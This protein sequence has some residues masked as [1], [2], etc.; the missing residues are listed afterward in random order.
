MGNH[1]TVNHY[2]GE[3]VRGDVHI[4]GMESFWASLKRGHY[5]IYHKMS[6]EHLHRYVNEFAG[7]HNIRPLDTID[8][9]GCVTQ[10]IS[11]KRPTY[12]RLIEN[13]VRANR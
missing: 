7:R 2:V 1:S 10:H 13:G 11:G 4:N 8:M 12:P 9:M 5:G 3:Y 6:K